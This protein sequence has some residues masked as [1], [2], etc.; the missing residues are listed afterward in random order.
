MKGIAAGKALDAVHQAYVNMTGPM[1]AEKR[2]PIAEGL[3]NDLKRYNAGA[4]PYHAELA[5]YCRE[6][7]RR[8]GDKAKVT[9]TGL[10]K[11]RQGPVRAWRR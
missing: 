6:V 10:E 8:P 11:F 9:E 2:V 5:S 3:A 7:Q 4:T 1:A